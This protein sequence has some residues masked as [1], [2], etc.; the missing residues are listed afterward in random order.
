MTDYKFLPSIEIR[1]L[2]DAASEQV[3]EAIT[4]NPDLDIF[5]TK[6]LKQK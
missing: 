4:F 2:G 6:A 3:T 5:Q 1:L